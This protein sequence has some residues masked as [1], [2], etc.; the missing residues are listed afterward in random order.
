[1]HAALVCV[2]GGLLNW[3]FVDAAAISE[4]SAA[5]SAKET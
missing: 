5:V 2:V 3:G 4:R 1:M